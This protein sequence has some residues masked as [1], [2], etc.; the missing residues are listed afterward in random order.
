MP[1]AVPGLRLFR[2]DAFC[3][4][5]SKPMPFLSPLLRLSSL[6]RLPGL[7]ALVVLAGLCVGMA[8][9]SWLRDR[10]DADAHAAFQRGMNRAAEEVTRQFQMPLYG[11]RAVRRLQHAGNRPAP[12]LPHLRQLAQP[13]G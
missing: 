9:G 1:P 5:H 7:P 12:Y 4:P 6:L 11:L 13:A 10:A 3:R 8:G 2:F